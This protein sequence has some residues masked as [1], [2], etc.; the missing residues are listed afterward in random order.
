MSGLYNAKKLANKENINSIY[1]NNNIL[2]SININ[3]L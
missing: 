3:L 1:N 2:T